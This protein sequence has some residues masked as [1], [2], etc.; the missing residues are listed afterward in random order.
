MT[1][2]P[3]YKD[4]ETIILQAVFKDRQ[5]REKSLFSFSIHYPPFKEKRK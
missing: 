5:K 4:T 2:R 3:A 1:S